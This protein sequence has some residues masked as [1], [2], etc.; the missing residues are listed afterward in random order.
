MRAR[1]GLRGPAILMAA[2]RGLNL[3]VGFIMVPLLIHYL[4][5]SGFAAWALLLSCSA[6][7]SVLDVGIPTAFRR[8]AA[9]AL[10]ARDRLE[11]GRL[12]FT[13]VLAVATVYAV[14]VPLGAT[15][16]P[17]LAAWLA[18]PEDGALSPGGMILVVFVAVAL[19][20][21]LR[22]GFDLLYAS[23]DFEV[24]AALAAAQAFASNMTAAATAAITRDLG[25]TLIAFWG[26][27]LVVCLVGVWLAHRRLPV[28]P[29]WNRGHPGSARR[30]L[31]FGLK[32][33]LHE[34]AQVVNF[35]FD[36]FVVLG[37]VGLAAVPIYEVA[38]RSILALRSLPAA[39][40]DT[41][42]PSA[43][44]HAA[45]AAGLR[46]WYLKTLG[47]AAH[48]VALFV[49][50]PM[51]VAPVFLT[52]WVGN[53]GYAGR[54]AFM[55]LAAGTA[56]NLLVFPSGTLVQ[57]L[58]RPGIQARAALLSMALNIPL[59]L[60]LVRLWGVDGAAIG[61]ALAMTAG[62]GLLARDAHRAIGLSGFET[63]R[64]VMRE[65][66]PLWAAAAV[67][68]LGVHVG[69]TPT[70]LVVRAAGQHATRAQTLLVA[71]LLYLACLGLMLGCKLWAAPAGQGEPARASGWRAAAEKALRIFVPAQ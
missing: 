36:K 53:I 63:A 33:Q 48:S 4:L 13:A 11:V 24:V 23:G 8:Q 65:A 66:W 67:F 49:L 61:T 64:S 70:L 41:F 55:A 71:V 60:A 15:Q 37:S 20:S 35:Q 54:W 42:L 43:A 6:V 29:L 34:W 51:A 31:R 40:M 26:A 17:R 59:S 5:R 3:A 19:R 62:A 57:A 27:Q 18:L 7:F 50:A 1:D 68:G 46:R 14:L 16:A 69:F 21:L 52:A 45:D 9:V 30:L 12:T 47:L 32:V 10:K 28:R 56:A 39:G 38:N 22:L 58:D 44:I 25:L 2:G